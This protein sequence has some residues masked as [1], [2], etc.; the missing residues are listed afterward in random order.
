MS[1]AAVAPPDVR[2]NRPRR[3]AHWLALLR[4]WR[5]R[6]ALVAL[7]VLVAAGFEVIPPLL[8]R[9]II[10]THLVAGEAHGLALLAVL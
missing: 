8:M 3:A 2:A 7:A 5:A 9:T 6:V 10:D 4:P 1:Q